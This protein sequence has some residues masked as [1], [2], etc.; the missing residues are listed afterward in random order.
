MRLFR[1][2]LLLS[3]ALLAA[4]LP[5]LAAMAERTTASTLQTASVQLERV[6]REAA[7]DGVLEA[8]HQSTVAAQ[9]SARVEEIF[10]DVGDYV[11]QGKTIIRFTSTEQQARLS[12]AEAGLAEAKARLAEAE[13]NY[14][15]TKDLLERKLVAQVAFDSA[16]ANLKSARARVEAAQAAI[17]ETREGTEY[18]VIRAPYSGLVVKRHIEVGETATVGQPLMTGLSLELLRA[19]VEIPQAYIAPLREHK[20]ARVILPDGKSLDA[21]ALRIP[22]NADPAT[23]TF[24]VQVTLPEGEHGV[25]PGTLVKVAFAS[26]EQEHMFLPAGA[27]VQRSEVTGVYVVGNDGRVSFRYVRVGT[28]TA[29]GRVPILAGLTAGEKVANDPIAAG[30]EY[31][32]QALELTR[33]A[34]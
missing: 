14:N 29:D 24:R 9:T 17:R 33:P 1:Y 16:A 4:G 15:R 34:Q 18:T 8:V 30:V 26:G 12:S 7:F 27:V 22:P 13:L 20:K 6:A 19:V 25:F 23:H 10:F 3:V 21:S 31:K 5:S 28:P 11:E 32:K 2:M